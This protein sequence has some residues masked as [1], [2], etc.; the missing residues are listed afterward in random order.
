MVTKPEATI[1]SR[2][3]VSEAVPR[4]LPDSEKIRAVSDTIG[5][6]DLASEVLPT[7][8]RLPNPRH[9][10]SSQRSIDGTATSCT[11]HILLRHQ[12]KLCTISSPLPPHA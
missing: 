8:L 1:V 3:S 4:A 5:P 2:I 7:S 9:V 12:R 11:A 10:V 6:G